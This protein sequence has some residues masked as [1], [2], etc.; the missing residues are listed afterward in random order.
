MNGEF[1]VVRIY[2]VLDF[3]V[4]EFGVE[5]EFLNDMGI[6]VGSKFGVIFWF[7]VSDDYFVWCKD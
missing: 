7:G 4:G 2:N 6:F 3:E 1:D 5:V